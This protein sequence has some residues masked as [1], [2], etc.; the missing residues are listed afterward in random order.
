[1]DYTD[2]VLNLAKAFEIELPGAVRVGV[3]HIGHYEKE[4]KNL[5]EGMNVAM[6]S[7]G[8]IS[9]PIQPIGD[10]GIFDIDKWFIS[11]LETANV[12]PHIV[13]EIARALKVKWEEEIEKFD[14]AKKLKESI[15]DG[16]KAL[17]QTPLQE[18]TDAAD[19][20]AETFT[21]KWF[22]RWEKEQPE[23]AAAVRRMLEEYKQALI[24]TDLDDKW[25][26][27]W[28]KMATDTENAA[29]SALRTFKH[30]VDEMVRIAE[31]AGRE[32][33][34]ALAESIEQFERR[35]RERSVATGIRERIAGLE[36]Q[37]EFEVNK[38]IAS[39]AS[40]E[41]I[42]ERKLELYQFQIEALQTIADVVART[43]ALGGEQG[44][45]YR[46]IV[47]LIARYVS[48][49]NGAE[50]SETRMSTILRKR[51]RDMQAMVGLINQISEGFL[52]ILGAVT[53]MSD[54]MKDV[55]NGLRQMI[56]GAMTFNTA[57]DVWQDARAN[58]QG[59]SDD[60]KKLSEGLE[61]SRISTEALTAV[62]SGGFGLIGGAV[63]LASGLFG[64][65]PSPEE[66]ERQRIMKQNT[67]SLNKLRRNIDE[68]AGTFDITGRR[69]A[70]ASM[71]L[72]Q[73]KF[74]GEY[75]GSGGYRSWW[76]NTM[77]T[78]R[79][80][81][82]TLQDLDAIAEEFGITIK[83][84]EGVYLRP[85][86]EKLNEALK[87]A[88]AGMIGFPQTLEGALQQAQFTADIF[89]LE[90]PQLQLA[91][92]L[93]NLAGVGSEFTK[94][95]EEMAAQGRDAT[96]ALGE[97]QDRL[98]DLD[99]LVSRFGGA[100]ISQVP[101]LERLMELDLTSAE[102]RAEAEQLIRD[103]FRQFQQGMIDIAALGF[104][105]PQEF[106]DL[107]G[108]IEGLLD[109]IGEAADEGVTQDVRRGV[110]ITEMQ[111]NQLLAYQSTIATRAKETVEWL[112]QIN[113]T[114]TVQPVDTIVNAAT[115]P[116]IQVGA[117]AT[118]ASDAVNLLQRIHDI[119]ANTVSLIVPPNI[120]SVNPLGG[121]PTTWAI[122]VDV[123]IDNMNVG[124]GSV[125]E[126][127]AFAEDVSVAIRRQLG[128][129]LRDKERFLGIK[130]EKPEWN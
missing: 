125:D 62:F 120:P 86:L 34:P 49:I 7:M 123:N 35:L 94:W 115:Q 104:A 78:L 74:G 108:N 130:P 48:L 40:Q 24:T 54:E 15:Q 33:S 10:E 68:L 99:E 61:M 11:K 122:D 100:D 83:N 127:N 55:L 58:L 129:D 73:L 20:L 102:G 82:L 41:E 26:A 69:F 29:D 6:A 56:T 105:T 64:G 47:A 2:W 67:E 25:D 75:G 1:M 16:M 72:G 9:L 53:D 30:E 43:A 32:I 81:G 90:D 12:A 50:Q 101:G 28:T 36:S 126:A 3:M 79:R 117:L 14:P 63:Q 80:F 44:T 124:T 23:A 42:E 8:Q 27:I 5:I 45:L 66:L 46:E 89:D 111:A 93:A 95:L 18:V 96:E 91:A 51:L 17:A 84:S 97:W 114:L 87:E 71:A 119:L 98:G 60:A 19:K 121:G 116:N 128:R 4:V 106:L 85:G 88:A 37:L 65:G 59:M 52:S 103:L 107:L 112:K 110:G 21:E 57:L 38:L 22:L 77:D 113:Q 13:K 70:A 109:Q 92:T 39:G 31:E 76:R 118:A